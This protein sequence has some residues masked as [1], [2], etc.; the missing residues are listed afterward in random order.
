[1]IYIIKYISIGKLISWYLNEYKQLHAVKVISSEINHLLHR[2]HGE[3]RPAHRHADALVCPFCFLLF[4][5]FE[6]RL[7]GPAGSQPPFSWAAA[8]QVPV[9]PEVGQAA[10]RLRSEHQIQIPLNPSRRA[11]A[12]GPGPAGGPGRR[13]RPTVAARQSD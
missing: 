8:R 13:R 4:H 5:Q 12:H 7:S 10:L 3:R 11:R 9:P 1:M 2:K 6:T